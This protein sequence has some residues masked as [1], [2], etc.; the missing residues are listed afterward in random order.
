M[1]TTVASYNVTPYQP[2]PNDPLWLSDSD[3]LGVL[4]HVATIYIYKAKP[5]SDT[6]E[7]LRNSLSKL[8]VYYY[9]VA[10]RLSL[11]ESGRMEV[12]CNTKGVTLIEAETTK[13][14]GDYGDFSASGGDSPTAIE[15]TRFLGGEGLAIGVLISHPLTDATGLIHFM[16]RWAKLTRG[17]EL[18]PDEMPFLDRTLL[19]L[20]PNQASTPSVKLQELKPAPQTLGK[21][22]K[23][24][25]VALLKLTSS[26]IERLKKKANDHPSKE[27]SRPYS[28]FEVVVAHIW[29]CAS[30]A[31]AESG[32]NSNQPILVRFS[33]NF[34]NRLKPPL[35]QNYFGNALAK[36]ATPECYEGDII[37]NP[38]GF[39]AQKIRETSHAITE[40]FLRSQLNVGLGKWQLD[41]IRA[42][43]VG[44]QH[45]INTPSVGDHNI[46]LTS[47]MT[48]AVYESNFGWGKPVHYG[49]ASLFQVN[50]AG[51]LPSPDGDGVIV[52][53]FFQE[54]LMKLFRKFFYEDLYVSSL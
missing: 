38:L 3:Q 9:P 46:F 41:N 36:V 28:R 19:K 29:R 47:L 26:Q 42:F 12:N 35:P 48:M 34:R 49:L 31:R 24:R 15:L 23:K 27:G 6:I 13:T 51:I 45:L 54:A 1:V 30:M 10:D 20:L 8:L 4:G 52:N 22:Q 25:S 7:R 18:N 37:S 11:T 21:E 43:V 17:E 53:I 39:T 40:D 5:N 33:V 50:R 32:E 14:F 2:T 16:N 44:Q